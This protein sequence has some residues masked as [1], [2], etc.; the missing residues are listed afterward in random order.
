MRNNK[1]REIMNELI[2]LHIR[3]LVSTNLY[4]RKCFTCSKSIMSKSAANFIQRDSW[5]IGC[6]GCGRGLPV[7]GTE[8]RQ[9]VSPHAG[10][11]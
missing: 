9:V 7:D 11:R 1:I 8:H 5:A 3:Y 4:Y 10:T 6:E 2:I